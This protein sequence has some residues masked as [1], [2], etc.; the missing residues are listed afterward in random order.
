M[1]D[2]LRRVETKAGHEAAAAVSENCI[3]LAHGEFHVGVGGDATIHNQD[4][5]ELKFNWGFFLLY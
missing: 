3:N 1:L 5:A 2:A 4:L